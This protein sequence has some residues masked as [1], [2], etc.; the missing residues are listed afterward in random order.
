M[1]SRAWGED[2]AIV[3]VWDEDD[4]A[5]FAGC[6][7]SPTGVGSVT[8]GGAN[9]P[10]MVITSRAHA[11]TSDR[12]FNHYSLLATIEHLWH[13]DC[14]GEACDIPRSGLMTGLFR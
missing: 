13:L 8:L 11:R 7:A 4:Y 9:A 1:H 3:I 5:G 2:S 10:A 6:C 12:A 14:L